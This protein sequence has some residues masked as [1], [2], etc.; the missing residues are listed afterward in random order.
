MLDGR[1]GVRE[2]LA[3]AALT[4]MLVLP[5]S[6]AALKLMALL[7]LV[8][9]CLPILFSPLRV[10]SANVARFYL[11]VATLGAVWAVVGLLNGAAVVGVMDS[12]R[13]YVFWSVAYFVLITLIP[14]AG[15]LRTM[16]RAIVLAGIA[17]PVINL[18]GLADVVLD[19]GLIPLAVREELY[20]FASFHEGYVRI[21]SHN[22]GSLFFVVGYL[23]TLQVCAAPAGISRRWATVALFLSVMMV[24]LSGRRALW[25]GT[26]LTPFVVLF[27]AATTGSL[28]QTR[29]W[30]R[31]VAFAC[32]ALALPMTWA[33]AAGFDLSMAQDF[34]RA[35]FDADD[36]RAMQAPYLL[37]GFVDHL[38][39]GSG[40]G[41]EAGYERSSESPWLYEL[42]FHQLL[43]NFGLV[44][45]SCLIVLTA[46]YFMLARR[47]IGSQDVQSAL[48]LALLSGF[49]CFL[50]GA[51][52]NPYLGSFDFLLVIAVLPLLSAYA[53][54]APIAPRL[55]PVAP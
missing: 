32:L 3:I 25:L 26:A 45:V 27:A 12:V 1:I 31:L 48:G 40:F 5:R 54:R 6:Y 55:A 42:T 9:W 19:A 41:V 37:Q 18:A 53:S 22:I 50:G 39:L 23:V 49:L 47:F 33:A 34:A 14:L 28:A 20:L 15:G 24:M 21:T 38:F 46:R 30:G 11:S 4:A 16:H 43:F 10:F 17:I 8:F 2:G 52:T 7:A 29:H 36:E 35:A 51:Y 13:L 44:G